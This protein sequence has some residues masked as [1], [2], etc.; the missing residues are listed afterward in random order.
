M[1]LRDLIPA[2]ALAL[3]VITVPAHA[4]GPAID[5]DPAYGWQTGGT[6]N[7]LPLGG[8]FKMVGIISGFDIPFGDLNAADPTR[9]YTFYVSGLISGGT[10][11]S[12]TPGLQFFE[13][14]FTG[15]TITIYEDLSPEAAFVP[16]PPNAS[17]PAD[18]IDGT[19]LLSGSF[20]RFVV[21]SNDFTAFQVGNIEGDI[22]WSG[23]SLY[24]RTFATGGRPC[25]GLFTGGMT[26]R[27]S[28]GV[29]GY[30]YRHDGKIDLQ[31]PTGANSGTWGRIKSL[32][33]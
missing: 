4:A 16:N 1:K 21:Q 19:V 22:S 3:A 28:V 20:S 15:G 11:S 26:W 27:T 18:F 14:N 23:G 33:R 9:E 32:Y 29:P 12:G 6:P 17:V 7:N 5:W 31:C 10:V 25:P 8:E 2:A 30:L 24:A 13:T